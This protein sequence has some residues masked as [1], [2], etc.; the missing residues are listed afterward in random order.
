MLL[1]LGKSV[2]ASSFLYDAAR[3]ILA[4]RF[5]I[6]MAPLQTYYSAI[7]FALEESIVRKKFISSIPKWITRLPQVQK[8]WGAALQTLEGHTGIVSAVTFSPDSNQCMRTNFHFLL[9]YSV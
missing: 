4:N 8:D 5:V 2:E 9:A 7:V 3:F 6:E 1:Q